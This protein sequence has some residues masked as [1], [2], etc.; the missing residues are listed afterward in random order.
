MRLFYVGSAIIILAIVFLVYS[1]IVGTVVGFETT[2]FSRVII[3][4]GIATFGYC[5]Q[6]VGNIQLYRQR[7]KI[8]KGGH[9]ALR[10]DFI[11]AIEQYREEVLGSKSEKECQ[12]NEEK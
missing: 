6:V 9:L 1:S 5:L 10:R 4:L 12:S 3:F 11:A 7:E 2:T 8:L